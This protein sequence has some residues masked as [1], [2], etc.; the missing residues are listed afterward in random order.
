MQ[1][2]V[3]QQFLCEYHELKILLH[4]EEEIV[5][6]L[7]TQYGPDLKEDHAK[8]MIRWFMEN[9]VAITPPCTHQ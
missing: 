2:G 7:E 6:L 4:K 8:T 9:D 3:R 5:H 1:N